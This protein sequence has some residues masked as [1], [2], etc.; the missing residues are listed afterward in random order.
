M[1]EGVPPVPV[2]LEPESSAAAHTVI[3]LRAAADWVLPAQLATPQWLL[4]A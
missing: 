4:P 3:A 1:V 2:P